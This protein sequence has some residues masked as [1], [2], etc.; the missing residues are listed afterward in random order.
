MPPR[1]PWA[2]QIVANGTL[3]AIMFW[4][5]LHLDEEET[6]TTAPPGFTFG[7]KPEE[8][9]LAGLDSLLADMPPLDGEGAGPQAPSSGP[10]PAPTK[11]TAPGE[12]SGG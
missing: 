9:L 10:A 4:F 12:G 5:D 1:A 11:T 8:D 2:A 3:N 6:L 7:G